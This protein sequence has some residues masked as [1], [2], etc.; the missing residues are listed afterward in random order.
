V[1][2]DKPYP[3]DLNLPTVLACGT[4]NNEF[5]RD[6]PYMA[7]LIDCVLAGSVDPHRVGREKVRQLLTARPHFGAEI[8]A[9]RQQQTDGTLVWQPDSA[10][11]RNVALKLARGHAAYELSEPKLA[12]PDHLWIGPLCTLTPDQR[13]EFESVRPAMG[14]PEIG[15]RA[16]IRTLVVGHDVYMDNGWMVIQPG[17]YRYIVSWADGTLVRVVLSEYLAVEATW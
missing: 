7:C 14:W 17:R 6:E 13:A 2:L 10:R 11:V 5:S 1:L 3:E 4:C 9:G 12:D 8:L 15:S 16:F